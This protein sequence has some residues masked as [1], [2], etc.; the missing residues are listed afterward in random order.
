MNRKIYRYSNVE[1]LNVIRN[2]QNTSLVNAAK[3]EFERRNLSKS[4]LSKAESEYSRFLEFKLRRK[5]EPLTKEEWF[6]FFLLPLI[7]PKPSWQKNSF[8]ESEYQ[9][10][11]KHGFDRK[12]KQVFEARIL[13]FVFWFLMVM[14]FIIVAR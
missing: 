3:A 1:L 7:T 14:I 4:E 5:E 6:S 2:G 8:S 13:G 9:R 11:E 10:F 12:I